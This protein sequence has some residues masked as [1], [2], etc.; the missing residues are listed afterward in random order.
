MIH[1]VEPDMRN[2]LTEALKLPVRERLA[3][4]EKL[5]ASVDAEG[6]GES[7]DAIQAAW[8]EELKSRG[9]DLREGSVKGL[10]V[11]EAR[12]VVAADPT[13]DPR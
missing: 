7:E 10:S 2:V 1:F 4:A 13:G 9:A 8:F 12:R 3:M 6:E 11:D 5:L